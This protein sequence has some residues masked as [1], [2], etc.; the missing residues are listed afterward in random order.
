[1]RPPIDT[2]TVMFAAAANAEPVLEYE[3]R[4]MRFLRIRECVSVKSALETTSASI[5]RHR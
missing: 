5:G 3:T 4:A 1:M 2:G